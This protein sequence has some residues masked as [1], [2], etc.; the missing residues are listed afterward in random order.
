MCVY[1]TYSPASPRQR[2]LPRTPNPRPRALTRPP[3]RK[4][5]RARQRMRI[6]Q[7]RPNRERARE[8]REDEERLRRRDG[9]VEHVEERVVEADERGGLAV[10]RERE[11]VGKKE[12]PPTSYQTI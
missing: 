4:Q 9:R 2:L 5:H 8:R 1:I 10:V 6:A 7:E 12:R 11:G 3:N